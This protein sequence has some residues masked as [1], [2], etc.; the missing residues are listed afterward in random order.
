MK[1]NR[2]KGARAHCAHLAAYEL[3]VPDW[4]TA[5]HILLTAVLLYQVLPLH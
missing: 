3:C 1:R 5:V 2:E 4:Y